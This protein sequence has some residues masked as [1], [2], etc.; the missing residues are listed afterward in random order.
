MMGPERPPQLQ[1]PYRIGPPPKSAAAPPSAA[2]RCCGSPRARWRR[3]R[4]DRRWCKLFA[5]ACGAGGNL[6]A[7]GRLLAALARRR[8]LP[9]A[10]A[11]TVWP[12]R[13]PS[14]P[15]DL[16]DRRSK[17]PLLLS[18][19]WPALPHNHRGAP[20]C[21]A[22]PQTSQVARRS[23]RELAAGLCTLAALLALSGIALV[24]NRPSPGPHPGE[25]PTSQR[26]LPGA[27]CLLA[28]CKHQ[29][30]VW[31]PHAQHGAAR[32]APAQARTR[33]SRHR[34]WGRLPPSPLTSTWPDASIRADVDPARTAFFS[35]RRPSPGPHPGEP[36]TS[37]RG[38]LGAACYLAP[39]QAPGRVCAP[40][41]QQSG[42]GPRTHSTAAQHAPPEPRPAPGREPPPS[43]RGAARPGAA[44]PPS[45][46]ASGGAGSRASRWSGSCTDP[47]AQHGAGPL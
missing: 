38:L 40:H 5:A 33:A 3:W 31:A 11:G 30:G 7:F 15:D 26:G 17:K 14:C 6:R 37:Q 12:V 41:A 9:A 44:R 42:C 47:R 1:G 45:A 19:E 25:P 24:A 22:R 46:R 27:A 29:G 21:P 23:G 34:A 32:A 2:P 18:L 43:E 28:L 36:P 13:C 20:S 16:Q 4:A 39:M 35:A 8:W 10:A